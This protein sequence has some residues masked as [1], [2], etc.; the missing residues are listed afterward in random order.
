MKVLSIQIKLKLQLSNKT[1]TFTTFRLPSKYV[2]FLEG[3]EEKGIGCISP[4]V[5]ITFRMPIN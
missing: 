5:P 4:A 1:F 3:G 2:L